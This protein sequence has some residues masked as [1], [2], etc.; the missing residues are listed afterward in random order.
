MILKKPINAV[1]ASSSKV[2]PSPWPV[3]LCIEG[4]GGSLRGGQPGPSLLSCRD[5]TR[6]AASPCRAAVS[7]GKCVI[8]YHDGASLT[9]SCAPMR[10]NGRGRGFCW[11]CRS[12]CFCF[13]SFTNLPGA[14]RLKR[15][16]FPN[17][18]R[19]D[20]L[21]PC[22]L[23]QL[24]LQLAGEVFGAGKAPFGHF[25]LGCPE[26]REGSFY[27][28]GRRT[29]SPCLIRLAITM[30]GKLRFLALIQSQILTLAV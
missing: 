18:P 30:N 24:G 23:G 6:V 10:R 22:G 11:Q 12:G 7:R 19:R 1:A 8:G 17:N 3:C 13:I 2:G 9:A 28:S 4:N 5:S 20:R 25:L 29:G 27:R 21:A 15:R 16:H 26:I 14:G